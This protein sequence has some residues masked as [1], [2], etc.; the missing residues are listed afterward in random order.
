MDIEELAALTADG[1]RAYT[2][3][4]DADIQMELE[5]IAE[6]ES[7]EQGEGT[8]LTQSQPK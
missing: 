4:S 7:G 2:N 1:K 5:R 6:E 3:Y 8:R